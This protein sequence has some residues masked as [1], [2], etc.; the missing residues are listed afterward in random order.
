MIR[1]DAAARPGPIRPGY[2][3]AMS[4][5]QKCMK[6]AS[7]NLIDGVRLIDQVDYGVDNDLRVAT[8][9]RPEAWLFKGRRYTNLLALVCGD[10]GFVE[11]RVTDPSALQQGS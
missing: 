8:D 10:C 1:R 11:L 4:D 2:A 5:N 7:T 9:R 3:D 6:C